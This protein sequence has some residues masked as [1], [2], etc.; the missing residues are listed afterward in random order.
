[1]LFRVSY[2]AH[3]CIS[4]DNPTTRTLGCVVQHLRKGRLAF[5]LVGGPRRRVEVKYVS[6]M[7][8][9][10]NPDF[11]KWLQTNGSAPAGAKQVHSC[12]MFFFPFHDC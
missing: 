11:P 8:S 5:W 1:M 2:L 9:R 10:D 12:A 7:L 4:L 3:E 6:S